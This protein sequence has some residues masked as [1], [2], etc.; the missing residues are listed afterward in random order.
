VFHLEAISTSNII[1][2]IQVLVVLAGFYFSWQS[3]EATRTSVGF[4]SQNIQIAAQNLR[5][6]ATSVTTASESLR[7]ATANAQSQLYNQMLSQ[8]R[9]LQ[10]KFMD[11]FVGDSAPS[12]N[13]RARIEYFQAALLW[14]RAYF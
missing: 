3:L 4:A 7:L 12:K 6:A 2:K 13:D 10:L 14:D 8:G 5:I 11:L 9:V 1:G